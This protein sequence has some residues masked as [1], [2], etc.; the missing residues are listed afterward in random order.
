M[1]SA[2]VNM[3]SAVSLFRCLGVDIPSGS[4]R[5]HELV[6]VGAIEPH[7]K[8]SQPGRFFNDVLQLPAALAITGVGCDR[9]HNG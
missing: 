5:D 8:S 1:A 4:V 7:A 9:T 2:P 3:A 6:G